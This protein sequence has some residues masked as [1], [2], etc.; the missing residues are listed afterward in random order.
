[1]NIIRNLSVLIVF[2]TLFSCKN[3]FEQKKIEEK[4]SE[5]SL[6]SKRV[7][8]KDNLIN[9]IFYGVENLDNKW[10]LND[11][12]G[13]GSQRIK[14]D[15]NKIY[16][17]IPAEEI[18]YTINIFEKNKNKFIYKVTSDYS[19]VNKTYTFK[20]D[21]TLGI[22][23]LVNEGNNKVKYFINSTYLD[24]S[25]YKRRKCEECY[26]KFDC[27]KWRK[28]GSLKEGEPFGYPE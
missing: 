16:H 5:V 19:G 11:Y 20:Y 13:G 8:R 25:T 27:D 9:M 1:M 10:V 15:K 12:C 24:K 28:D 26:D 4:K 2:I 14:I 23:T 7:N 18:P 6:I 22:L 3:T 21:S 17:Y